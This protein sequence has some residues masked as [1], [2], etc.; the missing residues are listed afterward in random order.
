MRFSM[1]SLGALA[2]AAAAPAH[3][4]VATDPPK[5]LTVTGNVTAVTDYRFRGLTQTNED[6]ALQATLN[7][8]H[9]SGFY[10]GTFLSTIDG[11]SDGST[12]L[13][14]NYGAVEIDLYGGY[15]KTFAGGVGIDAGLLYYFYADG[16]SGVNTDFFEPYG[17]VTGT[18]GPVT[19]KAGFAYAWGGQKG[20]DFTTGNDDSLYLYGE[21]SAGIPN[22]PITLKGHVGRTDGSLGL[23]NLRATNDR[24]WDYSV[25]AEAAFGPF[26]V[27]ASYVDTT[28]TDK[29]KYASSLGRDATLLGYVSLSF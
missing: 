7:L 20:L 23:A 27:G 28:V 19:A 29:L 3:A 12:P 17:S 18:L 22:T 6:P 25:T 14:T 15:T 16:K 9:E 5:A 21:A 2:L 26:K 8:N 10:V 13:L 11:G 4:Q 24:Y 1:I